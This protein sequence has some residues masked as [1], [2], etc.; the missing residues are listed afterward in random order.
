MESTE[1]F[2]VI[3]SYNKTVY[4]L[5]KNLIDMFMKYLYVH[6]VINERVLPLKCITFIPIV[7]FSTPLFMDISR[8]TPHRDIHHNTP[9]GS[10][11][12]AW[13]YLQ[14]RGFRYSTTLSSLLPL[15]GNP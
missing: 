10:T 15:S 6:H 11:V 4:C 14:I 7:T 5:L 1:L 13:K 12:T 2:L 8:Y 3:N 9:G